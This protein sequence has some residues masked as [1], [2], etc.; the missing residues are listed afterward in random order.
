MHDDTLTPEVADFLRRAASV[1]SAE[2]PPPGVELRVLFAAG[3][4]AAASLA[5]PRRLPMFRAKMANLPGKL[6]VA[7]VGM[8]FATTGLAAA[9][10]LPAPV[11]LAA[12]AVG[13][14]VGSVV[15]VPSTTRSSTESTETTKSP[16][17]DEA[18][19]PTTDETTTPTT[20]G[21]TTPVTVGT[22]PAP[23]N[24]MPPP[25]GG[26]TTLP[27][28]VPGATVLAPPATS[29]SQAAQIHDFDAAC[30]NH[31]HY[32]SFVARNGAEPPC[33]T[34]A[35]SASPTPPSPSAPASDPA[36]GREPTDPVKA[37]KAASTAAA[38]S[39]SS[40]GGGKAKR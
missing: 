29:A 3:R 7:A 24:A 23:P 28:P 39:S 20:G 1:Y 37:A 27:P 10:A 25:A 9:N 17:V 16:E 15:P 14:I 2:A 6:A 36:A 13:D 26:G 34:T 22:N 11:R 38:V 32:V 4:P 8:T 31:G 33:A 35:R 5:P 40:K 19:T 18:T 30:G 12:A 21:T